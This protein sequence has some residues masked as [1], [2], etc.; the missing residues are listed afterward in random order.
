MYSVLRA[1]TIFNKLYL[2][3]SNFYLNSK[4]LHSFC[5]TLSYLI[6]FV[7]IANTYNNEQ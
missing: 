6:N 4:I 2:K 3:I 1:W 5:F 7:G